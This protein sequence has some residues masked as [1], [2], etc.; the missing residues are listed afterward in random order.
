MSL[1]FRDSSGVETPVAGLNGT[2]G[3][4]VP[5]VSLYQSGTANISMP[6]TS[7]LTD[8]FTKTVTFDTPFDD[9]D[10]VLNVD[11]CEISEAEINRVYNKTTTG[12]TV[13][14]M[15][16]RKLTAVPSYNVTARLP[17]QAF[18]LMTD[19]SRALDEAAIAQNTSDISDLQDD[20]QDKNLKTP[21][22]IGGTSQTT[23]DGA[24]KGLNDL[25]PSNASASNKLITTSTLSAWRGVNKTSQAWIFR[26]T[27]TKSGCAF[28]ADVFGNTYLLS[29]GDQANR[30]SVRQIGAFVNND[31]NT[32]Y[33]TGENIVYISAITYSLTLIAVFG[34][35]NYEAGSKIT[36]APSGTT[37]STLST[38]IPTSSVTSGSTAPITSGGVANVA[39]YCGQYTFD[40]GI[41]II[42]KMDSTALR[43]VTIYQDNKVYSFIVHEWGSHPVYHWILGT[44]LPSGITASYSSYRLTF[45]NNSFGTARMVIEAPSNPVVGQ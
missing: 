34:S 1:K 29:S 2:S 40:N 6:N 33:W 27:E 23:V 7:E 17:W 10:Y 13:A 22:T 20:K 37:A 38:S 43:R 41:S 25:V 26:R 12:F 3:E 31:M 16:N 19:E 44:E 4:L 32:T 9:T 28:F 39:G 8:L 36:S 21:L 35:L 24:L 14:V 30:F 15:Y 42:I 5:S 11:Q 18:K 45:T